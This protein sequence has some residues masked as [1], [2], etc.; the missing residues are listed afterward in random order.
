MRVPLVL[1]LVAVLASPALAGEAKKKHEP[2]TSVEMPFLIAPVVADGKLVAYAYISA[3]ITSSSPAAAVGI[4]EKT[5]FLQDAF[6]RDVNAAPIGRADAPQIVDQ[7]ALVARLL[8]DARRIAG[9]ADVVSY[10]I[11]EIQVAPTRPNQT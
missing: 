4:R 8:G 3:K 6:V 1:A 2:G 11:T 7:P 10:T 9:S 5:P